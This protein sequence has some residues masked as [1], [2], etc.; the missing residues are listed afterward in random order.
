V[1]FVRNHNEPALYPFDRN[2]EGVSDFSRPN[3]AFFFHLEHRIADLRALGIEA[4]LILFHPYDRWGYATMPAEADD[5]YLR[6]TSA[7][8]LR[9]DRISASG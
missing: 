2:A 5:R 6:S 8:K 7:I 1:P 9:M 4:D 3:P